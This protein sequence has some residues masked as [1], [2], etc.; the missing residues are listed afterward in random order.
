MESISQKSSE[1]V[2][3]AGSDALV[4]FARAEY[5]NDGG[6]LQEMS[7]VVWGHSQA[8]HMKNSNTAVVFKALPIAAIPD[9]F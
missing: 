5:H 6:F 8:F 1:R 2:R 3:Q 7:A 9:P 4:T